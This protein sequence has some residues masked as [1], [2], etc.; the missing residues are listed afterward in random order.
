MQVDL[1]D[2]IAA[3]ASAAGGSLRGIVRISGPQAVA[4]VA[5]CFRGAEP[6]DQISRST[7]IRGQLS[8]Q[9]AVTV[10][11]DLY[12]WPTQ[13]SYTRQPS[14]ELH[15]IGSPPLLQMALRRL[16]THGARLARPGEFTLR[17]FLAGRLDLTQAEAV[18]GVIDA[19][20]SDQLDQALTQLA[21]GLSQPLN[22]LRRQLIDLCADL[23]AGL[24]FVEDDITFVSQDE[25]HQRLLTAGRQLRQL[26]DQLDTRHVDN[27]IPRVALVGRPNAGKSSLLNALLDSDAAMVS[28]VA[29]TTRDYVTDVVQLDGLP[30]RLVDTA[31]LEPDILSGPDQAAQLHT[32]QQLAQAQLLIHCLDSSESRSAEPLDAGPQKR[33]LVVT[34]SDLPAAFDP[35]AGAIFTSAKLRTGLDQLR[36]S[37]R[38]RLA[39]DAA[40][41]HH[42][43]SSTAA[44]CRDSLRQSVESIDRAIALNRTKAG[45]ELIAAEIRWALNQLGEV[46]GEVYTDDILDRVFSR[47]CIGK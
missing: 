12:L 39:A 34:K 1:Q 14:A 26:T 3:I 41:S 23:E 35:P 40:S 47:F 33:L 17:A 43:L 27:A 21:G 36:A 8:V 9:P 31:G 29:G 16:C 30:V 18:L 7:V 22:E 44:R 6:L 42:I 13:R 38:N 19:Q 10:P 5:H 32:R 37:I 2:T 24:D 20:N 28:T 15:T 11:C 4:S 45:D 25:L 46:V